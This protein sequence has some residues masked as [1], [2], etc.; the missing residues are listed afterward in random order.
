MHL[1]AQLFEALR[2]T[3]EGR[4]FDFFVDIILPVALWLR[5]WLSLKWALG[6]LLKWTNRQAVHRADKLTSFTSQ[7]SRNLGTSA[8]WNRR[9]CNRLEQEWFCILPYLIIKNFYSLSFSWWRKWRPKTFYTWRSVGWYMY[10][11]FG[12]LLCASVV[13][14]DE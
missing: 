13:K 4:W 5:G 8:Y 1:A 12:E 3:T 2:Y 14:V 7:L 6:T 9:A 10:I 11:I